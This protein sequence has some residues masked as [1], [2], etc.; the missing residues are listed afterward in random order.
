MEGK[1]K[2]HWNI[3]R[4]FPP[5]FYFS[6]VLLR[7]SLDTHDALD[8]SRHHLYA[9]V[10]AGSSRAARVLFAVRRACLLWR[11]CDAAATGPG[12]LSVRTTGPCVSELRTRAATGS[13]RRAGH[14]QLDASALKRHARCYPQCVPPVLPDRARVGR[15]RAARELCKVLEGVYA[16]PAAAPLPLLQA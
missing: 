5:N 15:K 7:R 11:R 4:I 1:R 9:C 12:G 6:Q 2:C 3:R 16:V 8:A 14:P 10:P 13:L